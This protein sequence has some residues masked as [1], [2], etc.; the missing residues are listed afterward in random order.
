MEVRN[1]GSHFNSATDLRDSKIPFYK[2]N[3]IQPST[4][5]LWTGRDHIN[6]SLS[7]NMKSFGEKNTRAV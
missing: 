3:G 6:Y 5:I 1:Q 4:P 7:V 2:K